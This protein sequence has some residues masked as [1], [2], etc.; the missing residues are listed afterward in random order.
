MG[1]YVQYP[2]LAHS[3]VIDYALTSSSPM[4]RLPVRA[5]IFL[6]APHKGLN[7]DALQTLVMGQA[8]EGMINE[9]RAES[10]TLRDLTSRFR[11]IVEDN[12]DLLTCYEQRPTKTIVKVC[13]R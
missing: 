10:P 2:L 11:D 3:A 1:M 12:I 13:R 9:L 6:A 5:I 4:S 8:T 7:V